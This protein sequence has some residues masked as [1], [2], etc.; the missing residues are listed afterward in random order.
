MNMKNLKQAVTE[1]ESKNG[2]Q[3][4][5]RRI[6]NATILGRLRGGE[7]TVQEAES[8]LQTKLI[9]LAG[10][11]SSQ[12]LSND[13]KKVVLL[14]DWH[15]NFEGA[16][17]GGNSERVDKH[18]K[19]AFASESIEFNLI[20]EDSSDWLQKE[21]NL[22]NNLPFVDKENEFMDAIYNIASKHYGKSEKKAV[23]VNDARI[24]LGVDRLEFGRHWQLILH[25]LT[26]QSPNTDL[27]DLF[28]NLYHPFIELF[29]NFH[30]GYEEKKSAGEMNFGSAQ[31]NKAMQEL[32]IKV[33]KERLRKLMGIVHE[34]LD[35]FMSNLLSN[36]MHAEDIF[37]MSMQVLSVITHFA[38]LYTMYI[39]MTSRLNNNIVYVGNEHTRILRKYFDVL[40]FSLNHKDLGHDDKKDFRCVLA[41][42]FE[43]Y[44][45]STK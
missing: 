2:R 15:G 8:Y 6:V 30:K 16:C 25:H 1:I 44:F 12:Y 37:P 22:Q 9:S 18:L 34:E 39:V 26:P 21:Y 5:L 36:P 20:L 19:D 11:V 27:K 32:E 17:E 40:G 41:I 42:P 29:F 10:P 31:L 23:H 43:V 45:N 13:S 33:G 35:S 14:G 24:A 28:W 4:S 3:N 7:T 38:E